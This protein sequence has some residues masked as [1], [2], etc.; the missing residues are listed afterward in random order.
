[1]STVERRR[2][3]IY[4]QLEAYEEFWKRDH[5]ETMARRDGEDAVAVGINM[6]RMLREREKA[7]RDQ[8]FRGTRDFAEEDNQDQQARFSTWLETTE[9]LLANVLPQF[10][11]RFGQM[12]VVD[13]LRR[14]RDEALTILRD[15]RPPRLS[16]AVGLQEMTLS[17]EAAAE[18]DRILEEARRNPPPRIE[19]RVEV[20]DASFLKPCAP[21]KKDS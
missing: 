17:A 2:S 11:S 13:E 16:M 12:D 6:F 21:A 18:L 7:W 9:A 20:K 14:C 5:P 19:S 1:M 10:E 4:R 15:W 8:V 3:A